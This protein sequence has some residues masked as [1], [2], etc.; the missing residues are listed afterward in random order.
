MYYR[1]PRSAKTLD[2]TGC[3][4]LCHAICSFFKLSLD[5]HSNQGLGAACAQQNSPDSIE[6]TLGCGYFL[7]KLR[8]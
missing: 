1:L 3:Q 6:V 7:G 5:H 2:H 8:R 4:P